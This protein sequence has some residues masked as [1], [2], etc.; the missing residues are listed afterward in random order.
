MI[1]YHKSFYAD[2]TLI[3]L[4]LSPNDYAPLESLCQCINLINCWMSQ[5]LLHFNRDKIE[6]ILF[7]W[8]EERLQLPAHLESLGLKRKDT[9]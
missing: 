4:A 7:G 1:S 9:V 3:Y 5:N 6:L 8:R 2:D